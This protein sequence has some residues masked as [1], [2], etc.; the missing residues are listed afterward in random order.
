[1]A[2]VFCSHTRS[3]VSVPGPKTM[4]GA[5]VSSRAHVG[6]NPFPRSVGA[7][8]T[9]DV[10]PVGCWGEVGISC[11]HRCLRGLSPEKEGIARV[12]R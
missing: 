11:R 10:N 3:Y 9:W 1:M 4:A 8:G 5:R 2:A 7:Y 6:R 12:L